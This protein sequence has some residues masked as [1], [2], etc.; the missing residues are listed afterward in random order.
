MSF[1]KKKNLPLSILV[2]TSHGWSFTNFT[3]SVTCCGFKASQSDDGRSWKLD[4]S[5]KVTLLQSSTL[6]S[7]ANLSLALMC[8]SLIKEVFFKRYMT[9]ILTRGA[10]FQLFVGHLMSPCLMIILVS[11]EFFAPL[12]SLLLNVCCSSLLFRTAIFESLRLEDTRC[13]L[14]PSVCKAELETLKTLGLTLL[15]GRINSFVLKSNVK[16]SLPSTLVTL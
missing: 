10:C 2:K 9:T 12:A 8:F 7:L 16:L 4:S 5:E 3:V 14:C 11:G 15:A 6:W 1:T 13:S